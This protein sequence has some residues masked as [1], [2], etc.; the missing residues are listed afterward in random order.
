MSYRSKY[1]FLSQLE[2]FQNFVYIDSCTHTSLSGAIYLKEKGRVFA[3]MKTKVNS[4][5]QTL[6]IHHSVKDFAQ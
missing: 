1:C 4:V 3:I 6:R 2:G 5:D